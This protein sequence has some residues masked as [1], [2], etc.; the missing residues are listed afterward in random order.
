MRE[1]LPVPINR[2]LFQIVESTPSH[3]NIPVDD[4]QLSRGKPENQILAIC[5]V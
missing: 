4:R 2:L 1:A 5:A 3:P